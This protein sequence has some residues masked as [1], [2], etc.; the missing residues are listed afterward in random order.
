MHAYTCLNINKIG[1]P[2]VIV[3]PTTERLQLTGTQI[4]EQEVMNIINECEE[5]TES[6]SRNNVCVVVVVY[7]AD[8]SVGG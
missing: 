1:W 7:K 3:Q 6:V 4:N 2:V 8:Y 5:S